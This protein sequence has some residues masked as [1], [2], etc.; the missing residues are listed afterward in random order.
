MNPEQNLNP[1]DLRHKIR[2]SLLA[3]NEPSMLRRTQAYIY[4]GFSPEIARYAA[5][6]DNLYTL[7]NNIDLIKVPLIEKTSENISKLKTVYHNYFELTP[8]KINQTTKQNNLESEIPHEHI[9]T[10]INKKGEFEISA[11]I[12]EKKKLLGSE[13]L[14]D[15]WHGFFKDTEY[16]QQKKAVEKA[17]AK[18]EPDKYK[19]LEK[20][21]SVQSS[22]ISYATEKGAIP[23]N[24]LTEIIYQKVLKMDNRDDI[25]KEMSNDYIEKIKKLNT[26]EDK[27]TQWGKSFLKGGQMSSLDLFVPPSVSADAAYALNDLSEPQLMQY[28]VLY[29][30]Q[31][32]KEGKTPKEAEK[33]VGDT[34]I[35][36]RDNTTGIVNS[37]MQSLPF[38]IEMLFTMGGF[39]N[40]LKQAPKSKNLTKF[41]KLADWFTNA[42]NVQLL[43]GGMKNVGKI[44][45]YHPLQYLGK[46]LAPAG[47]AGTIMYS[48]K[49]GGQYFTNEVLN[50]TY[51]KGDLPGLRALDKIIIDPALE[52]MTEYM[53]ADY[54][55]KA[56][57]KT[58][59]GK[60][61][62][63]AKTFGMMQLSEVVEEEAGS[64]IKALYSEE[65]RQT[66]AAINLYKM[67]SGEDG[68]N[69]EA[70]ASILLT[71]TLL[72][73][74]MGGRNLAID[75][76][77]KKDFVNN[78]L[79]YLV[80][81]YDSKGIG[82]NILN[83]LKE[84]GT[85]ID[86]I[87]LVHLENASDTGKMLYTFG[88]IGKEL[89][90]TREEFDKTE[91]GILF[92]QEYQK[93]FN[94]A[95]N[96]L[97]YMLLRGKNQAIQQD[98]LTEEQ[99]AH[100]DDKTIVEITKKII[101][102]ISQ[103]SPVYQKMIEGLNDRKFD[104][105]PQ[106]EK[107]KILNK[108]LMYL[109]NEYNLF[110]LKD[111]VMLTD[112]N[113]TDEQRS[114][115]S[116]L[117]E[118]LKIE[119][120]VKIKEN[121]Q[122][123]ITKEIEEEKEA[124]K[125]VEQTLEAKTKEI[126]SKE[127]E[128]EQTTQLKK[129][130]EKIEEA[131]KG[132][133]DTIIKLEN[134]HKENEG[135]EVKDL[136]SFNEDESLSILSR[137]G[138]NINQNNVSPKNAIVKWMEKLN[139]TSEGL[140]FKNRA[141]IANIEK[142][143]DSIIEDTKNFET[144]SDVELYE[145]AIQFR[146]IIEEYYYRH[147]KEKDSVTVR[148]NEFQKEFEKKLREYYNDKEE[149]ETRKTAYK[150]NSVVNI[151]HLHGKETS[152]NK[153]EKV[154]DI[155]ENKTASN[156]DKA[157][158]ILKI[159]EIEQSKI[160]EHQIHIYD[161]FVK[162]VE[163]KVN[164]PTK[165]KIDNQNIPTESN[166]IITSDMEINSKNLKVIV[167]YFD[168]K[169][170][171]IV[172]SNDNETNKEIEKELIDT[173]QEFVL[174]LNKQS[175][176]NAFNILQ[177]VI[178]GMTGK[179][180][181]FKINIALG[182]FDRSKNFTEAHRQKIIEAIEE[183]E[184]VNLYKD[185]FNITF[186]I[187]ADGSGVDISAKAPIFVL[188]LF[189]AAKKH[190]ESQEN[191]KKYDKW[192]KSLNNTPTTIEDLIK[193]I[194]S[195]LGEMD[196]ELPKYVKDVSK[197]IK[198]EKNIFSFLKTIFA[199]EE[200][201]NTRKTATK[202][203]GLLTYGDNAIT[204][205]KGLKELFENDKTIFAILEPYL[206]EFITEHQ[207]KYNSMNVTNDE[208]VIRLLMA[209]QYVIA[210]DE[211]AL[212]N[213]EKMEIA[214]STKA[215][216]IEI[217]PEQKVDNEVDEVKAEQVE[218]LKAKQEEDAKKEVSPIIEEVFEVT[219]TESQNN[220]LNERIRNKEYHSKIKEV[221]N[222]LTK[223]F[224]SNESIEARKQELRNLLRNTNN[225]QL[226]ENIYQ[227]ANSRQFLTI[228]GRKHR[229][230][231]LR[232]VYY[233]YRLQYKENYII[234]TVGENTLKIPLSLTEKY[235]KEEIKYVQNAIN[236]K[237][238]IEK[239]HDKIE[240]DW[241]D[242]VIDSAM[243][244]KV[245]E[246]AYRVNNRKQRENNKGSIGDIIAYVP[247]HFLDI[248]EKYTEKLKDEG[249]NEKNIKFIRKLLSN[250]GINNR[251][252]SLLYEKGEV[253]EKELLSIFKQL[254]DGEIKL[255]VE[256][257]RFL[258]KIF[259]NANTNSLSY[260]AE[261]V[262][263]YIDNLVN[264]IENSTMQSEIVEKA[265]PKSPL[266]S[267]ILEVFKTKGV[268][269]KY[270]LPS[271]P[272]YKERLKSGVCWGL[273]DNKEKAIYL[274]FHIINAD[275]DYKSALHEMF[276]AITSDKIKQNKEL[277]DTTKA[278]VTKIEKAIKYLTSADKNKIS[279]E[280]KN[281]F[282]EEDGAQRLYDHLREKEQ[283]HIFNKLLTFSKDVR[284][285]EKKEIIVQEFITHF[286]TDSRPYAYILKHLKA[287]VLG[288]KVEKSNNSHNAWVQQYEKIVKE[289]F[290]KVEELSEEQYQETLTGYFVEYLKTTNLLEYIPPAIPIVDIENNVATK[291]E[292]GNL[293]A[294]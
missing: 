75:K 166:P 145:R 205:V 80:E 18:V 199:D 174:L 197:K 125:E 259:K 147:V 96:E 71:T 5:I 59:F 69:F 195:S 77:Y 193:Y 131:K 12:P 103:S 143:L 173:L 137:I 91:E 176:E 148:K 184:I 209:L 215:P 269:I 210:N 105:I 279:D 32:I 82:Q 118:E 2:K 201:E 178:K 142:I 216:I 53:F 132:I 63:M 248:P 262:F 247:C 76:R 111:R 278:L 20:S 285:N 155:L 194:K 185:F 286:M 220:L 234:I 211:K 277:I 39:Q 151:F 289:E 127:K 171:E 61:K 283:Q 84:G 70:Q 154:Y 274:P 36:H 88:S 102:T 191:L 282:I 202:I 129:E 133:E 229:F 150:F 139:I 7:T 290:A 14:G 86:S 30:E 97:A 49:Y 45:K 1:Y 124:L 119:G 273:Y 8:K 281:M 41:D 275:N 170:Q 236:T 13:L 28:A 122:N 73:T 42:K 113:L 238:D 94:E 246:I 92:N 57:Y 25:E 161:K 255:T 245:K 56:V 15:L 288:I 256:E 168:K 206:D 114:K 261:S 239:L 244:S 27:I 177:Y 276:H 19:E 267:L 207:S 265:I 260:L 46:R 115:V 22:D 242:G 204:S 268:N 189:N 79:E 3:S 213:I 43:E 223:K 21:Y 271:D 130:K 266:G 37:A 163:T 83:K 6:E 263:V 153:I 175:T 141:T 67:L 116:E 16:E 280:V 180:A 58:F 237:E 34:I 17:Y 287:D 187:N 109:P 112:I 284:T 293:E 230:E 264:G 9:Y 123:E 251:F 235:T 78:V 179:K 4:K 257:K 158:D 188:G 106:S 243:T 117:I 144:I 186:G 224:D 33:I 10:K 40:V 99:A 164:V 120:E 50:D 81:A 221:I 134:K 60:A 121:I 172:E 52:N 29:R 54:A 218:E 182:E 222:I 72:Q 169:F 219:L 23:T 226:L 107:D 228:V 44:S 233:Q 149:G 272:E 110:G 231:V 85:F 254:V 167:E 240:N 190:F 183:M 232:E 24:I 253:Y 100:L 249:S 225:K 66:S 128:K 292:K 270:V 135:K 165:T 291:E 68:A 196:T 227:L 31:L 138:F 140:M 101:E 214:T 95:P 252:T 87:N 55:P 65:G 212:E 104:D 208:K 146:G 47:V 136:I 159:L 200:I 51:D 74:I 98:F 250:L 93:K 11:K 156:E 192:E 198:E 241:R 181:K 38:T 157:K 108:A 162:I 26:K 35:Q 258:Q 160:L 126:E 217:K 64:L 62:Q 48:P 203:K 90:Q 294:N 89:L 152:P